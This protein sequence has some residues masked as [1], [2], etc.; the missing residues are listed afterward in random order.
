[1]KKV[2]LLSLAALSISAIG[3]T[4]CNGDKN[5]GPEKARTLEDVKVGLICLHDNSSTY[6]KNFID[7]MNN[8]C[9]NAG[10]KESQLIVKTN[11]P[12]EG[13]DCKNA[14]NELVQAGCNFIV[15]DSFGHEA[16]LR[17]VAAA[18][19]NVQFLHCTGTTAHTAE[20]ANFH[21]G[22]ASIY[23]GRY[24]A[25]VAAGLKLKAMKDAN[26]NTASKVGYV[27]AYTYAEV[28]SG[29]TSWYLGVKSVVSDVTMDV[30]FT[31][32]WYDPTAEKEAAEALINDGA[33]LVSQHA[34]SMGAPN[35]CEEHNV[36]N[37]SYNGSTY[38]ACPNTFIISSRIDWTFI[39]EMYINALANKDE[40]MSQYWLAQTDVTGNL[41]DGS[42][43]L[44]DV[45]SAAAP[46][47]QAYLDL[48]KYE[49]AGAS[50]MGHSPVFATNT[51]TVRNAYTAEG[52][53][54]EA[55]RARA[56]V[57]DD[58]HLL[59]YMADVNETDNIVD[60]NYVSV[61][62]TQVV[63]GGI[64]QESTERSAPYFDITIDGITLRN[65]KF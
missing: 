58:Y 22:F 21:N 14:A 38:D 39:F 35:A 10:L 29:Y 53:A 62:D 27:G 49:L 47:T 17:T 11:V 8:A 33:V 23:E 46:R 43:K 13:D 60:G 25:G 51:F 26:P 36:P 34:D 3:M 44:T 41:L 20:L 56:T 63:F 50:L 65:T 7:S 37:V 19:P 31:G 9:A 32:S 5:N 15:A 54:G 4:A 28:I 59:T 48:L 45:G 2:R 1:M 52:E 42:V 55:F 24:L 6:D 40:M 18:N 61:P 64:F 30:R 12:E 16:N 57:D